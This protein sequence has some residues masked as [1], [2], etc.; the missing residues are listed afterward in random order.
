MDSPCY[1][2]CPTLKSQNAA[3]MN[4]CTVN[5][6]VNEEVDAWVSTLPGGHVANYL[7]PRW[8]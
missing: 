1:Q 3:A 5:R 7:K 2:N 8:A 6:K 4:K